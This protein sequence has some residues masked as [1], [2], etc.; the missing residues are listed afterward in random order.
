MS[1]FSKMEARKVKQVLSEGWY[2]QERGRFKVGVKEGEC[3][4]NIVYSGIKMEK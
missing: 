3:S 2:Q 1:L 4:G